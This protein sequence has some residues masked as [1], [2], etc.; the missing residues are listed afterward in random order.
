MNHRKRISPIAICLIVAAAIIV[1]TAGVLVVT[2]ATRPSITVTDAVVEVG[3]SFD[4]ASLLTSTKNVKAEEIEME[5]EVDTGK[6]GDYTVVFT[7]QKLKK[8]AKVKVKDTT[9]PAFL[10]A[11]DK[12]EIDPT[13]SFKM[14]DLV[15]SSS[16]NTQI[17]FRFDQKDADFAKPGSYVI[18]II[19]TD[20]G[21]NSVKKTVLV[22]VKE[23]ETETETEEEAGKWDDGQ[24]YLVKVNRACCTVTVY[25]RSASGEYDDPVI[26][27]PCSVGRAGQETPLGEYQTQDRLDW[28]YM[29]DG[30]Y[31]RY[32]IR[33]VG[34]I[35]FHSVPYYSM[36][37]SDL[38]WPEYNKLGSPA[39]LGCIRLCV[40]DAYWLYTNCP[41]GFTTII[42]DDYENPGPLGKPASPGSLYGYDEN[43]TAKRGWDPTDWDPANPWNQ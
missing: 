27:F 1:L 29:V 25:Q 3:S 6:I 21:G 9:L 11:S 18:D 5:G 7:Y 33:V 10:L 41:Y 22:T 40:R 8:S 39:S 42:Y 13:D 2:R 43:D 32:F 16:D 17:T 36:D 37:I 30:T 20:E 31:A 19:A 26:A 34:G 24:P 38:E 28:G 35:L 15:K 23:P 12:V 4:P 14:E